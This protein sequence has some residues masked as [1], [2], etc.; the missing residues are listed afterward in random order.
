MG[1]HR[2][3]LGVGLSPGAAVISLSHSREWRKEE[4]ETGGG[5]WGAAAALGSPGLRRE[6]F[7]HL[8]TSLH[9]AKTLKVSSKDAPVITAARL[10]ALPALI[11]LLDLM[12]KESCL[13]K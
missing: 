6:H 1:R 3:L 7:L 11:C 10:K 13:T 2:L 12:R 9:A 8:P 4:V 5:R